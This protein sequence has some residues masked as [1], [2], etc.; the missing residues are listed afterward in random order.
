MAYDLKP[1]ALFDA[2]SIA[3]KWYSPK[4][5]EHA[6]RVAEYSVYRWTGTF[7]HN[8]IDNDV[9]SSMEELWVVYFIGM[10]HDLLED[11]DCPIA[12]IQNFFYKYFHDYVDSA[13][14]SIQR[15]THNKEKNSYAEYI[16][17]IINSCDRYARHVK[18][19]DM[20]DHW[21]QKDTLS[22]RLIEKYKPYVG[23]LM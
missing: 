14:L 18:S 16:G 23:L 9:L 2:L 4:K 5:L 10:F 20:K 8:E 6:I 22:E 3:Q 11:S 19:A 12:V 15:L 1:C 21:M 7:R 17:N 13:I